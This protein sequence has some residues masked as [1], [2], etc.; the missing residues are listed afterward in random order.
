MN[1]ATLYRDLETGRYFASCELPPVTRWADTPEAAWQ[2]LDS[3][4]RDQ[5]GMALVGYAPAIP[6]STHGGKRP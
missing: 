4:L 6:E 1:K 3:Y 2:A 5:H